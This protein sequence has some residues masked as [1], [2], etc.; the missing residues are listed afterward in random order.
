[1]VAMATSPSTTNS[2]SAQQSSSHRRMIWTTLMV[3]M[4]IALAAYVVMFYE[5]DY[6]VSALF[7]GFHDTGSVVKLTGA[8][9]NFSQWGFLRSLPRLSGLRNL[10]GNRSAGSRYDNVTGTNEVNLTNNGTAKLTI[11]DHSVPSMN[12]SN[13]ALETQHSEFVD[14]EYF[15]QGEAKFHKEEIVPNIAHFIWFSNHTFQFYHLLSIL[16]VYKVMKAER[17]LFHTDC[18]PEGRYW[19][20]IRAKVPILEIHHREP[21][22]KVFNLTLN[23][24]WHQADVASLLILMELGGVY[25]DPDI[26]VVQPLDYLRHYECVMG[27][28]IPGF[29]AKGIIFASKDSEFLR[30]YYDGYRRYDSRCWNCNSLK[31]P[32]YLAQK[33]PSLIHVEE[34]SLIYPPGNRWRMMFYGKFRWWVDNFTIHVWIRNFERREK[35][36]VVSPDTIKSMDSAFG[37]MCRFIYY[38]EPHPLDV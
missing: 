14:I 3:L 38:D 9:L 24:K 17:I 16:S 35:N 20:E 32:N 8:S 18:E 31:Y 7:Y 21:P 36:V 11:S 19:E 37:Q 25:F 33:Y 1:M 4:L 12:S 26:F 29:I 27:R 15:G 28:E 10:Q 13:A 5:I 23:P 6:K 22:L 2:M 34:T 30:Y